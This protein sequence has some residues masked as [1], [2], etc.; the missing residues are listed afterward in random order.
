MIQEASKTQ[1]AQV[2]QQI[3]RMQETEEAKEAD[4]FQAPPQSYKIRN[5][6]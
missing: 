4:I 3:Q 2:T 1:E 5:Q 6:L